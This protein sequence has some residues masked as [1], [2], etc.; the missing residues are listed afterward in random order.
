[1]NGRMFSHSRPIFEGGEGV[2]GGLEPAYYPNQWRFCSGF[3][4]QFLN[5]LLKHLLLKYQLGL[6]SVERYK[7]GNSEIAL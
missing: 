7:S 5:Q 6:N 2:W 1:M 4:K 3:F